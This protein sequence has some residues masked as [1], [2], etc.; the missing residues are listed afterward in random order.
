MP[1]STVLTQRQQSA[2]PPPRAPAPDSHRALSAV[3]VERRLAPVC[4]AG[5]RR[6]PSPVARRD[7]RT[8]PAVSHSTAVLSDPCVAPCGHLSPHRA[9]AAVVRV[10]PICAAGVRRV[11]PSSRRRPPRAAMCAPRQRSTTSPRSFLAPALPRAFT[12]LRGSARALRRVRH[13]RS[14][15]QKRIFQLPGPRVSSWALKRTPTG[16]T[17]HPSTKLRPMPVSQDSHGPDSHLTQ[18]LGP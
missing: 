16:P 13:R 5:V 17:C 6:P 15:D 11:H 9:L 1:Y 18:R 14:S 12:G 2:A 10:A 8:A 4:V 7:V 3:V